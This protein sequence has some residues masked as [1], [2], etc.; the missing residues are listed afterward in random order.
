MAGDNSEV[1]Y[2]DS[3]NRA[4]FFW[5]DCGPWGIVL[6][7]RILIIF[8]TWDLEDS[9]APDRGKYFHR[10]LQQSHPLLEHPQ[11]S[12]QHQHQHIK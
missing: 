6:R 8:W 2:R 11:P 7:W 5:M 10:I 9:I 4:R 3:D 1:F 12:H